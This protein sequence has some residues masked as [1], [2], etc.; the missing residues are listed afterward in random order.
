MASFDF[1]A[2]VEG[3]LNLP[4]S[5]APRMRVAERLIFEKPEETPTLLI[6]NVPAAAVGGVGE[7][8]YQFAPPYY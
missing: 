5:I 1:S 7:I 6:L 2:T 3:Q 8:V 4:L